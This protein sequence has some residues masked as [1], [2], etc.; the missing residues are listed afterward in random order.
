MQFKCQVC[1]KL[2][3][4]PLDCQECNYSVCYECNVQQNFKHLA[5]GGTVCPNGCQSEFD[6][7]HRFSRELLDKFTVVCPN[8]GCG[9]IMPYKDLANHLNCDCHARVITC[10]AKDIGCKWFGYPCNLEKHMQECESIKIQEVLKNRFGVTNLDQLTEM[11]GVDIEHYKNINFPKVISE[12]Q[13]EAILKFGG[14]QL[15][16]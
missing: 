12:L 6:I 13:D 11:R 3:N 9:H 1:K 14:V 8:H 4:N 16:L 5:S 15:S 2:V 10:S 7:P